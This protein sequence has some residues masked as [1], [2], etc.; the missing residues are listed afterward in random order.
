M[1]PKRILFSKEEAIV[2]DDRR[3]SVQTTNDG[4]WNLKI[5]HA[6]FNDSGEYSCQINT[7]PV[8]IKRVFLSVQGKWDGHIKMGQRMCKDVKP[9]T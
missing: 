7:N 4:G 9:M 6:R 5:D 2:I 1:N 8:K 3:V